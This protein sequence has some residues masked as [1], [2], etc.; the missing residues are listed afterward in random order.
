[1]TRVL[2]GSGIEISHNRLFDLDPF[3]R[4]ATVN[5]ER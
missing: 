3:C 2:L 5:D 1:V 4:K